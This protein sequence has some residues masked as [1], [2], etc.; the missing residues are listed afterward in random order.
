MG[1]AAR[2]PGG[3]RPAGAAQAMAEATWSMDPHL[4]GSML[5]WESYAAMLPPA[6]PAVPGNGWL[7]GGYWRLP[8]R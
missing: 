4:C 1:T 5:Q 8:D 3:G 7:R 2:S 6:L